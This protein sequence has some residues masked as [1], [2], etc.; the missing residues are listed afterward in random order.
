[1]LRKSIIIM[2]IGILFFTVNN[3]S[4]KQNDVEA[5]NIGIGPQVGYQRSGDADAGAFMFGAV[6]RAKL[7]VAFGV[8]ASI[9]YREDK[10]KDWTVRTWP[11]MLSA[12]FYPFPQFYAVGGVG[13]HHST[14]DF[15]PGFQQADLADQTENPFGFHIGGGAEV[16]LGEQ[17]R[18]FGDVRYVFLDYKFEDLGDV[19][20]SEMKSNFYIINLGIVFGFE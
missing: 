3:F 12:L 13:W 9:N 10:Y 4:Q 15:D 7:S 5:G 14:L 8:E 20:L 16:P 18:L 2:I 17:V 6:L 1:M 11:V 19:P